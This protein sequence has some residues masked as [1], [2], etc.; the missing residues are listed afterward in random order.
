MFAS[1]G[2]KR[3][4]FE[5]QRAVVFALFVRELKGRFGGQ[6]R[7]VFWTLLQPIGGLLVQIAIFSSVHKALSPSTPYAVFLLTGMIPYKLSFGIALRLMDGIE[8]N[9]GLFV[10]RQV[11][12]MDT[13][14]SRTLL[15]V[16]MYFIIY[17][18]ILGGMGWLGYSVL[19]AQPLEFISLGMLVV[20]LGFSLGLLLAMATNSAPR[21]RVVIRIVTTPLYLLSG[22]MLSLS[23]VPPDVR[24]YL[25]WN[26]G[27]HVVELSRGYFFPMH[28][29]MPGVSVAYVAGVAMIALTVGLSLYRVRR[30]QL[31]VV[32]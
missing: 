32:Q 20:A 4:P 24:P 10:Y 16:T 2:R 18:L 28:H 31:I 21:S 5:I 12:P 9:R 15:E 22:V 6:W 7:G 8:A 25:L 17:S 27:L 30:H 23:N 26:P 14:I 29:V 11:K 3:S 13:L 19:P 1:L